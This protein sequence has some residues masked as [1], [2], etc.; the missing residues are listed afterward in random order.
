MNAFEKILKSLYKKCDDSN[1]VLKNI[2]MFDEETQ[3]FKGIKE[4]MVE[5]ENK[6]NN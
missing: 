5:I 1:N 2:K 3:T 6:W 4:I